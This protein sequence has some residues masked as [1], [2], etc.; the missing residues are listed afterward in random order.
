[1]TTVLIAPDLSVVIGLWGWLWCTQLCQ[2]GQAGAPIREYGQHALKGFGRWKL[3]GIWGLLSKVLFEC[4]KCHAGQVA[5]WYQVHMYR[6]GQGFDLAFI[7][8]A[9]GIAAILDTWTS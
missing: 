7:I 3:S 8:I 5:L 6:T 4:S 2:P 1:M 9:I